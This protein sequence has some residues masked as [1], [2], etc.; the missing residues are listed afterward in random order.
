MS[1]ILSNFYLDFQ[2]FAFTNSILVNASGFA[3]GVA[4]K[5]VIQNMLTLLGLP[6]LQWV[7]KK[8]DVKKYVSQIL[9]ELGWQLLVFF[10]TILFSF[11]LLEYLFNRG[12]LGMKSVVDS[13]RFDEYIQSKAEAKTD[14][15]IPITQ[16]DINNIE[17]KKEFEDNIVHSTVQQSNANMGMNGAVIQ[18]VL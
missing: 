14:A 15:I 13:K 12:I 5:E 6:A 10:M 11:I 2:K 16:D 7:S 18:Q 4:T 1:A 8:F 3:I 17:K 9:I